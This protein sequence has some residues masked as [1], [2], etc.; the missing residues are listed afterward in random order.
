MDG[1]EDLKRRA[2]IEDK[3]ATLNKMHAHILFWMMRQLEYDKVINYDL[4]GKLLFAQKVINYEWDG[5]TVQRELT[6][7]YEQLGFPKD[8]KEMGPKPK[9]GEL[10][11]YALPA[12]K[13]LT[14]DDP[15]N[16]D[17]FPLKPKSTD[18]RRQWIDKNRLIV[19]GIAVLGIALTAVYF[20]IITIPLPIR[21]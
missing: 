6:A 9:H 20:S 18:K 10:V 16:L 11:K 5:D 14:N 19:I 4:V 8:P 21:Q 2:E 3:V 12:I 7:I 17:K 15:K 13:K 1:E